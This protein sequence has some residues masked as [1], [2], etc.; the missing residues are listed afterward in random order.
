MQHK[1]VLTAPDGGRGLFL[2]AVQQ[3][4][5]WL[6]RQVGVCMHLMQQHHAVQR[7]PPGGPSCTVHVSSGMIALN[8]PFASLHWCCSGRTA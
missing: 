1:A 2:L 5:G 7:A 4:A 6:G 8:H 3:V